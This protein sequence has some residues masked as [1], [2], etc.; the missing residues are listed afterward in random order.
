MVRA[1][2]RLSDSNHSKI[3]RKIKGVYFIRSNDEFGS[4]IIFDDIL[5]KRFLYSKNIDDEL[6]ELIIHLFV[7]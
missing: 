1:A 4:G 6:K 7:K 5:D 2:L 3:E